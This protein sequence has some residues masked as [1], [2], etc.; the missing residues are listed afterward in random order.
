[1]IPDNN[2]H[3]IV[4]LVGDNKSNRTMY[5]FK[6]HPN[7]VSIYLSRLRPNNRGDFDRDETR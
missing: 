5:S 7:S 1:M 4:R 3:L 6:I 2:D